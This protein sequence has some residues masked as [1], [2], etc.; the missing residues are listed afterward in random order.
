VERRFT[1]IPESLVK[2][3]MFAAG[4]VCGHIAA[5]VLNRDPITTAGRQLISWD[6]IPRNGGFTTTEKPSVVGG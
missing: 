5:N 4:L 2:S 1:L 3:L 6:P